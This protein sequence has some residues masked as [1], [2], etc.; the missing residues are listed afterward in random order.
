MPKFEFQNKIIMSRIAESELIINNRGAI[1]HLDCIPTEIA[2]NIITVGDPDRVK[3]VSKHFDKIECKNQH[4]EFVTHTGYI[5]NKRISCIS[6]GIGTDNIDIVLNELDALV[7]IDFTTRQIKEQLT[8]LNII[9]I[10]TSGS[11]QKNIPVDSFVASSHGLGIDNLLNFYLL[12]NNNEEEQ[13]VQQ[14][15][16][17][18]QLHNKFAHPYISSASGFLLKHFVTGFHQGITVTCPGFYG[19]QGRVL[20]MGLANAA[21]IDNL[22]T[23]SFGNHRISNFE[24]ETAGIYGLSKILGHHCLSLNAI[25]ANRITKEFSKEANAAVENLIKKSLQ[26]LTENI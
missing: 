12:Q 23:F 20:R 8:H 3:E 4:R 17:Q 13:L 22:T 24:M 5:G 2:T 16:T 19:P 11:L 9:R 10:G 7:N 21:L 14:F 25:V 1:Y 6:T 15:I 26:I 18:T